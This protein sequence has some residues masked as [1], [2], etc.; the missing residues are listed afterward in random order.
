MSIANK[1]NKSKLFFTTKAPEN[2][3]FTKL[4]DVAQHFKQ[5]DIFMVQAMFINNKAKFG[6]CPIVLCG[7]YYISLPSHLTKVVS[8][9]M[10]DEEVITAIN[11]GQFG[12]SFYTYQAPQGNFYS[13]NWVDIK[14]NTNFRLL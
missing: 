3:V 2:V 5:D 1:Y 13:V 4:S 14:Q 8:D 12:F 6:A 10:E 7:N 9:M 11:N